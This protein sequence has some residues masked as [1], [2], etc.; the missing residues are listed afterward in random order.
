[1]NEEFSTSPAMHRINCTLSQ[2]AGTPPHRIHIVGAGRIAVTSRRGPAAAINEASTL[3]QAQDNFAAVFSA[4]PSVLCII[5]LDSLLYREINDAYER[6]TGYSRGEVLGRPSIGAGLWSN[7]DDRD[8][9]FE[10]LMQEGSLHGHQYNFRTKAGEPFITLLSAQII[11]FD[12][13]LCALVVAEDITKHR[14]EEEARMALIQRLVNTQEVERTRVARE[15]HD[16]I[17]QSLALFG[18]E[19]EAAR[20]TLKL[21][22][23]G[24]ERM[25]HFCAKVKNLGHAVGTL[26]HQLHSSELE[27]LGLVAAMK[28]LCR[29]FTERYNIRV[30]CVC[31]DLPDNL[32]ADVSLGLFRVVQEALHNVAKHSRAKKVAVEI[33]GVPDSVYLNVSD[34]GIGFAADKA[35]GTRGLGL[36]SMR[37]RIFLI[38]GELT[39][40]SSPGG[41]TRI[42]AKVPRGQHQTGH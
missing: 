5:Q 2:R 32:D 4:N 10:K 7:P 35:A 26:S 25:K 41:G 15:L 36:T 31:S 23:D 21:T 29:E 17:G 12:N 34:D 38:R 14:Q 33:R 22:A 16:S 42:E 1:M 20:L 13:E 28:G 3:H 27:L 40:T 11:E 19:L 9:A 24:D 30:D 39:I 8:Q 18:M 6:R 37:E